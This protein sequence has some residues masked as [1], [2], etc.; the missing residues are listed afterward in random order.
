MYL[1][2]YLLTARL[3]KKGV[4]KKYLQKKSGKKCWRQASVR[5]KGRWRR[6]Y[7]TE[8]D[9]DKWSVEYAPLKATRPNDNDI[10]TWGWCF[11]ASSST[12]RAAVKSSSAALAA[13]LALQIQKAADPV[14]SGIAVL[15]WSNQVNNS[16]DEKP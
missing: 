10:S 3:Q 15:S 2:T 13:T 5:V 8:I 7:I 16:D 9:G 14:A 12:V 1:L 6:Q 4:T 11:S